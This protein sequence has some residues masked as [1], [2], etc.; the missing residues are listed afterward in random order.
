MFEAYEE[1]HDNLFMKKYTEVFG[2][3]DLSTDDEMFKKVGDYFNQ[4]APGTMTAEQL[5]KRQKMLEMIGV[6]NIDLKQSQKIEVD[7]MKAL[8]TSEPAMQQL[9]G[10][11]RDIKSAL[12]ELQH[13]NQK[14][15]E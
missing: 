9:A 10:S 12:S 15:N 1:Q 4:T 13:P 8:A 3:S 7:Q 6:K 2:E 5:S 11:F 14:G